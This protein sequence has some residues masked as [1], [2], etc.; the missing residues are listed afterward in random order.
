MLTY[1]EQVTEFVPQII[2]YIEKI[3]SNGFAYATAS[4]D[5]YFDIRSFEKQHAYRYNYCVCSRM[6]T[7]AH[8]C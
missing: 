4:G 2:A 5:V 6:L 8:V 3:I 7:Y 1:T